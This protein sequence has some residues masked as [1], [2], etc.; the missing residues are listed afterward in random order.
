MRNIQNDILFLIRK[1]IFHLG[2]MCQAGSYSKGSKENFLG[3]RTINKS[4]LDQKLEKIKYRRKTSTLKP[5]SL[6]FS[7]WGQVKLNSVKKFF[8][9][10]I[11]SFYTEQLRR[12]TCLSRNGSNYSLMCGVFDG[13]AGPHCAQLISERLFYYLHF[14]NL[15]NSEIERLLD[16]YYSKKPL[17]LLG[18]AITRLNIE[19]IQK[20]SMLS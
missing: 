17:P 5:S 15:A 1:F 11:S 9:T 14:A 3:A 10:S 12:A 7:Y 19:N 16:L 2:K 18:I 4:F 8:E 6:K 13:H 20:H